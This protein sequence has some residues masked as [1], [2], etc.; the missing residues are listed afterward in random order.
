[1][2]T[3]QDIHLAIPLLV[4]P[5]ADV[6]PECLS[7]M[8]YLCRETF[9]INCKK[10]EKIIN[11][12]KNYNIDPPNTIRVHPLFCE[13][14]SDLINYIDVLDKEKYN[15]FLRNYSIVSFIDYSVNKSIIN[16]EDSF[17]SFPSIPPGQKAFIIYDSPEKIDNFAPATPTCLCNHQLT[18]IES[19]YYI[20]NFLSS[21][22]C[23]CAINL[24]ENG[25]NKSDLTPKVL[26]EQK[27]R[28]D[29]AAITQ[30]D[31]GLIA[32]IKAAL[33]NIEAKQQPAFFGSFYE[34]L[35]SYEELKPGVITEHHFVP[36]PSS[37][38]FRYINQLQFENNLTPPAL[39]FYMASAANYHNAKLYDKCIDSSIK[40]II[41]NAKSSKDNEMGNLLESEKE[42]RFD[43]N[44][45]KS[46]SK[47]LLK[48]FINIDPNNDSKSDEGSNSGSGNDRISSYSKSLINPLVEYITRYSTSSGVLSRSWDLL[49]CLKNLGLNRKAA[50]IADQFAHVYSKDASSLFIIF[51][52]NLIL[53]DITSASIIQGRD[54]CFP[55][56]IDLLE[57]RQNVP[58]D[59]F[60]RF[61]SKIFCTVGSCLDFQ[62][63]ELLLHELKRC[64]CRPTDFGVGSALMSTA[65]IESSKL[66]FLSKSA[67]KEVPDLYELSKKEEQNKTEKTDNAENTENTDNKQ[68]EDENIPI[69]AFADDALDGVRNEE[70]EQLELPVEI[71]D[72][73]YDD[74]QVKILKKAENGSTSSFLFSYLPKKHQDLTTAI[75]AAVGSTIIIKY[76]IKNPY[77][78]TLQLDE[79]RTLIDDSS[80][81]AIVSS[82][83]LPPGTVSEINSYFTPR[84]PGSYEI[85]GFEFLFFNMK[86]LLSLPRKITVEAVEKVPSFCIKSNLPLTSSLSLYEGEAYDFSLWIINTGTVPITQL[87]IELLQPHMMTFV[88]DENF[89]LGGDFNSNYKLVIFPDTNSELLANTGNVG[90]N[91]KFLPIPP[92][93]KATVNCRVIARIDETYFSLNVKSIYDNSDYYCSQTIKQTFEAKESLKLNRVFLMKNNPQP[94]DDQ[95]FFNLANN[96]YVGYEIFNFADSAF[97]FHAVIDKEDKRGI[98]GSNES[99]LTIATYKR[100]EL[101]TDGSDASRERVISLTKVKEEIIGRS[102]NSD[103]RLRV[104]KE[105]SI[106]QRLE[107][108]WRFN[109]KV[110]STRRG[111]LLSESV[112]IDENL[113][114]IVESRQ[115]MAK[116]SWVLESDYQNKNDEESESKD[117]NSKADDDNVNISVVELTQYKPYRLVAD[118]GSDLISECSLDLMCQNPAKSG[119][120]WEETLDKFEKE[121]RSRYIFMLSFGICGKF[122][123]L[124][125]HSC[126]EGK[127]GFTPIIV[128]I[129]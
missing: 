4:V 87:I 85:K 108:K 70:E 32:Q 113:F 25:L 79:A 29:F 100:S 5:A 59:V 78:V 64:E 63:Q 53:E 58:K 95:E 81:N 55:M 99:I 98:I 33:S 39:V 24:L 83:F 104:A 28:A 11:T 123:M 41:S 92:G 86:Q 89:Q 18:E 128:S 109:W 22:I 60:S 91:W 77:A 110:S 49:N 126:V 118:F 9:E 116:I 67:S 73:I 20:L 74:P 54:L 93:G 66:S 125:R 122:K 112:Q 14:F 51:A 82:Q 40:I 124:L 80:F 101:K 114:D 69:D 56:I 107:N 127:V 13:T 35:A 38:P 34:L 10:A 43:Q 8:R 47:N 2:Q 103:E 111:I 16:L 21:I 19:Y 117:D 62:Q 88:S 65:S 46:T 15:F 119:I 115:I 71:V 94:H 26:R 68:G 30:N 7:L 45:S 76:K 23:E 96:I 97:Q 84:N 52:L 17:N 31:A 6:S 1:M 120:M 61:I 44:K 50:V 75:T 57:H 37:S 3:L 102:L 105:V 90:Q 106:M 121:G 129:V 36:A 12:T 42:L 48:S 72:I 27:V